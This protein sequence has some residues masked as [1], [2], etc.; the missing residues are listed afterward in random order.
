M[1]LSR[2]WL[3]EFVDVGPVSDRDFAEAMTISGS[4]VE[5]TEDLGAEIKNVVVGRI[6]KMERH[7]DSD[8]MWVCQI[9][10][11]QDEPVQIV[12][13]AWNIH[14]GDLVPVAKD[15]SWLPGGKHITRGNLRGV[16]SKGMLCSLKELNLDERDF[17]YAVIEAAA[18]LND[19]KP[20]DPEKPSIPKDV[21][22]G[23][24]IFGDVKAAF[25]TEVLPDGNGRFLVECDSGGRTHKIGTSCPNIH[26]CDT[27]ALDMTREHICT[28]ADLHAEQREFPHC[29]P[30][31]IFVLRE[32]CKPGDDIRP[33]IGADDHVVEFE[34]TPNRPDC[35]S[36]IGLARE[37]A[38][39]F[40]KPLQLHDPEVK[41]GAEG[42]L[43][44]L[45][46]VETPDPD[47]CPRYTARMVRNVKIGP[48]PKW[49]RE[50]LRSSGVRPI[51]NI[52]DITNYVMLEYGQ[53]MHAFD[54][55][56]VKGGKIVVRRA[57]AGE[58]LT[59]LDGNVR[60]L[61]P[62]MLVIADDTRAVGLAGVMGGLNSEIVGDT[63]DVVFESANFDGSCIRKTALALGMRTEASAKFEK[64]LDILNT[65]PAV[66]RACEL[67]ELLGAGE[68]V[69][70][71][72][73]ILN[74]VPNPVTVK[75]EDRKSVV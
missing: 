3:Q 46:D 43:P 60:K 74:Y 66:N 40:G 70:G 21:I 75:F 41:G 58:E 6:D 7:P 15:N 53:P 32:D 33:V 8:H 16:K 1:K 11:G 56:Y 62:D 45:L 12:T 49:M 39:T 63:V 54:Y 4:K 9:D 51:N 20:I 52:V 30:D 68:V 17:P 18:L 73:D 34:I 5:V 26:A 67:V 35:L 29:I 27:V 10:A 28:L 57:R 69:D 59:T 48:S 61:T 71:V 14:E 24:K 55:R 36:V 64:G 42:A 22:P 19:Y 44:D 50:R 47:L 38:V 25:V 2:K 65:L 31:G 23:Y 37:A 72:I 13:G